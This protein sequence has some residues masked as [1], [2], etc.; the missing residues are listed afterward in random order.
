[1]F[2]LCPD[3]VAL[4]DKLFSFR[5]AECP[6]LKMSIIALR[7]TPIAKGLTAAYHA[8]RCMYH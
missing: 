1:M 2:H 6:Q 8:N 7:N 3:I 4:G 5:I